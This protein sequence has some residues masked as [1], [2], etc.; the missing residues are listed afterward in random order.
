[1]S[2]GASEPQFYEAL[3]RLLGLDPVELPAQRDTTRW[4]ATR[5]RFQTIFCTRTRDAWCALLE[6]PDICFAPVLSMDEAPRHP[7]HVQRGSFVTVDGHMQPAPAPR[8][9]RTPASAPEADVEP[10]WDL[11]AALSGWVIAADECSALEASGAAR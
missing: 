7:H 3:V 10:G 4:A 6:G 1:M 5:S 9:S 2:V 11:A 8:F